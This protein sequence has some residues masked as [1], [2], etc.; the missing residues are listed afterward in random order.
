MPTRCAGLPMLV[1][2]RAMTIQMIADV[3][4]RG[5]VMI[6]THRKLGSGEGS[7]GLPVASPAAVSSNELAAEI[8]EGLAERLGR[9]RGSVKRIAAYRKAAAAIRSS[10]YSI[11][12]LWNRGDGHAL[13]AIA[14]VTPAVAQVLTELIT[15]KRIPIGSE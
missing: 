12:E 3:W 6:R 1:P 15:S 13:T 8:L 4:E 10:P 9:G 11:D 14:G 7:E 2:R 5:S